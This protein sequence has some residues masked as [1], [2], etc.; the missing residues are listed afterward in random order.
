MLGQRI[1]KEALDAT[2]VKDNLVVSR[3]TDDGI[4]NTIAS[5]NLSGFIGVP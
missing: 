4:W 3:E 2:L 5:M 1:E